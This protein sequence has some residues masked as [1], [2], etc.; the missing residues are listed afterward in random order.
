MTKIGITGGIGSGKSVVSKILIAM[1]YPVYN[2]DK[3]AKHIINENP[4]VR[5]QLIELFG[6]EVYIQNE[7]NRPFL[8]NIIFND[9]VA[10]EKVNNIVHPQVR[11]DFDIF[12]KNQNSKLVFNEAAILFETGS[13]KYYDK[14]ILVTADEELRINRVMNR[15]NILESDVRARMSEQW[16]DSKKTPL[17]DYVIMNN[18]REFLISQVETM[19]KS[20]E[21]KIV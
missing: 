20:I 2:S 11:L 12:C 14:M 13:E 21:S 8:A 3:E 10:L 6:E 15:D 4:L 16:S 7:L 18:E 1:N 19:I 17:T 5:N 9:K